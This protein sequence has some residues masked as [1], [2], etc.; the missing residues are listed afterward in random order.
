MK[1]SIIVSIMFLFALFLV[2]FNTAQ[3]QNLPC[4]TY[5]SVLEDSVAVSGST[6]A[7]SDWFTTKGN[8]KELWLEV[9]NGVNWYTCKIEYPGEIPSMVRVS[10]EGSDTTLTVQGLLNGQNVC[11]PIEACAISPTAAYGY[12]Y[13]LDITAVTRFRVKFRG[14][15]YRTE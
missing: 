9:Y 15:P 12:T 5:T 2:C 13:T 11:L 14:I 7:T 6:D 1:R 10:M 4:S 8:V 3:A